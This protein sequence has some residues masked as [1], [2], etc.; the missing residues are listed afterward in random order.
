M[1]TAV[2]SLSL[3]FHSFALCR[4]CGATG[5]ARSVALEKLLDGITKSTIHGTTKSPICVAS[6]GNES[7]SSSINSP[8]AYASAVPVGAVNSSG[9]RSS[10]S[11]YEQGRTYPRHLMAPG[12]DKDSANVVTEDVGDGGGTKCCG[13]SVA[14]AYSAGMLALLWSD[15]RYEQLGRDDFLDAVKRTHCAKGQ[16]QANDEYGAGM[17]TYSP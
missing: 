16:T 17:I 15:S 4:V 8:A 10:F 2:I 3:G 6:V 5:N 9:D 14:T 12:G 11:N 7:A 1:P 13:T